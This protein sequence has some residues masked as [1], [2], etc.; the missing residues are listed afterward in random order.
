MIMLYTVAN[1]AAIHAYSIHVIVYLSTAW[2]AATTPVITCE[3]SEKELSWITQETERSTVL[4]DF[5]GRGQR[6][7]LELSSNTLWV[8][9][10]MSD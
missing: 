4:P 8:H 9:V 5:V 1:V 10:L 2:Q 7:T 6:Q 3:I